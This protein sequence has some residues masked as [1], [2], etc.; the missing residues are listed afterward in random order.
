MLAS[1]R[2]ERC[3]GR[4]TAEARNRRRRR[5][6]QS[7][8]TI[9]RAGSVRFVGFNVQHGV[10]ASL[11]RLRRARD[12]SMWGNTVGNIGRWLRPVRALRGG[13]SR[14]WGNLIH[15]FGVDS[16]GLSPWQL[17]RHPPL[18]ASMNG[19]DADAA[20]ISTPDSQPVHA[21]EDAGRRRCSD[22][23]VSNTGTDAGVEV[24]LSTTCLDAE[25]GNLRGTRDEHPSSTSSEAVPVAD[26]TSSRHT[27]SS[28]GKL[29]GPEGGAISPVDQG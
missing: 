5:R 3:V 26:L 16:S 28:S 11:S 10:W 13:E 15:G 4:A 8:T 24:T 14:Q 7:A 19:G 25:L 1:T 27:H 12:V 17:C 22:Q 9:H 21:Q 20:R 2:S 18:W 23:D 6:A 29:D